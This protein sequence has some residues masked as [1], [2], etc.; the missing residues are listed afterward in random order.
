MIEQQYLT[1]LSLAQRA[2]LETSSGRH[3]LKPGAESTLPG[4]GIVVASRTDP[5][6]VMDPVVEQEFDD[7]EEDEPEWPTDSGELDDPYAAPGDFLGSFPEAAAEHTADLQAIAVEGRFRGW[8]RRN[9]TVVRVAFV[10][11]CAGAALAETIGWLV[12]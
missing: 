3:A 8:L 12:R 1:E 7:I 10:A 11:A 9:A 5:T 4:L 2:A 6:E